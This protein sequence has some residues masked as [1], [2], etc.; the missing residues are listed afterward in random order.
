MADD[1]ETKERFKFLFNQ[2]QQ[3]KNYDMKEYINSIKE[4]YNIYKGEIKDL[5]NVKEMEKRINYFVKTLSSQREYSIIKRK[6]LQN[7]F[8][9]KDG[10]FETRIININN[11]MNK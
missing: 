9:I 1:D 6:K 7:K 3:L 11:K 4:D 2:I 10:I 8:N 5:L